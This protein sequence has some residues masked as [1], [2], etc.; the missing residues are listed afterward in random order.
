MSE[1]NQERRVRGAGKKPAMTHVTIRLPT[2]M[3]DYFRERG[4]LSDG[5]RAALLAHIE[6]RGA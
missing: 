6:G 2:N 5:I 1:A 4:G 3:V